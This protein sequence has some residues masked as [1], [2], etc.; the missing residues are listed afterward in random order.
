MSPPVDCS[1]YRCSSSNRSSPPRVQPVPSQDSTPASWHIQ[2]SRSEFT[3]PTWT[4]GKL[5]AQVCRCFHFH[6]VVPPT[7]ITSA[8]SGT[9][10]GVI[11]SWTAN[12]K[13]TPCRRSRNCGIH[14]CQRMI[15]DSL[16]ATTSG[17]TA[18]RGLCA[19]FDFSIKLRKASASHSRSLAHAPYAP[20]S[21]AYG[22]QDG[23]C[24]QPSGDSSQPIR[25]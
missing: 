19:D 21:R 24:R 5:F 6:S 7:K 11:P 13:H 25:F 3:R 4:R 20:L 17:T 23:G 18:Q 14:S 15:V 22:I 2:R 10:F 9:S 1:R 16:S 12:A 8:S